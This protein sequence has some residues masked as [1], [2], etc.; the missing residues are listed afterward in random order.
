M[1]F[2]EIPPF[3]TEKERLFFISMDDSDDWIQHKSSVSG[4]LSPLFYKIVYYR[5]IKSYLLKMYPNAVQDWHTDGVTLKRNTLILHPLTENYAPYRS[6]DGESTKPII[7]DTQ[8][9]HSVVN[10]EYT[11]MNLQIPFVYSYKDV[12]DDDNNIVWKLLD[13]FYKENDEQR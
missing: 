3:V 4:R 12:L 5:G 8:V 1:S 6:I 10:N 7:A 9:K 2:I 13:K 11:R